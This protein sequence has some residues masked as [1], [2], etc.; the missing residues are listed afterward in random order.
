MGINCSHH[1][2]IFVWICRMHMDVYACITVI[3]F[4]YY[5]RFHRLDSRKL[6]RSAWRWCWGEGRRP[7]LWWAG[8][9]GY[10]RATT[11]GQSRTWGG[12]CVINIA[13]GKEAEDTYTIINWCIMSFDFSLI[14]IITLGDLIWYVA[15]MLS[16]NSQY[17]N[18]DPAA[19]AA[20]LS[21][22]NR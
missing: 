6:I 11:C 19:Q 21:N 13:I 14:I 3:W 4:Q 15:F 2:L 9:Y 16:N 8:W 18:K 17:Q 20:V 5:L 12:C 10:H 7:L 22:Q 1:S